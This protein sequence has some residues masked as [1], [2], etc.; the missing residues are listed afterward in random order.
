MHIPGRT[1]RSAAED[2][3]SAPGAPPPPARRRSPVIWPDVAHDA[4]PPVRSRRGEGR[5]PASRAGQSGRP[6]ARAPRAEEASEAGAGQSRVGGAHLKSRKSPL[7]RRAAPTQSS[8]RAA[9]TDPPPAARSRAR[10]RARDRRRCRRRSA[11]SRWISSACPSVRLPAARARR[12]ASRQH[13]RARVADERIYVKCRGDRELRGK[14][15]ARAGA[16]SRRLPRA[17]PPPTA[18]RPRA[19]LRPAPEHGARRRRG[20]GDDAGARPGDRRG[21][22]PDVQ[23]AHRDALRPR[24]RAIPAPPRAPARTG[25][26]RRA[27]VL[28]LVSPP[29]RTT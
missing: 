18:P 26:A 27:Q 6:G 21:D 11:A 8:T 10:R 16:R 1:R 24:R 9:P 4:G 13:R 20:D 29:L 22:H 7:S 15:H 23:T 28:I 25:H 2:R 19:G 5:E 17:P 14:L 12:K 3:A